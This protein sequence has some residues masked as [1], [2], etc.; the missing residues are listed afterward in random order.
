MNKF[1]TFA[2]LL[3]AFLVAPALAAQNLQGKPA[4]N[5]NASEC[6]NEPRA[7]TLEEVQGE[8]VLIKL[9]GIG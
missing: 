1:T 7:K 8:V 3:L 6:V 2:A 9:W 5:F 4:P